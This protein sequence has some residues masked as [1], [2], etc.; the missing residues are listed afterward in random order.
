MTDEDIIDQVLAMMG[1]APRRLA[2]IRKNQRLLLALPRRGA[3][4][5]RALQLYQ[6][7]RLKARATITLVRGTALAGLHY[8][9]LPKIKSR[10]V[11]I[12]LEPAF[13]KVEPDSVGIMVGSP[14]HRV[15]RAIVS[16]QTAEGW[17]VAKVA[18]GPEA[19]GVIAGETAALRSLPRGTPGSPAVLGI[20]HGADIAIMRMPYFQGR[21]IQQGDAAD[22][23]TLLKS[24]VSTEPPRAMACFPEWTSIESALSGHPIRSKVLEKLSRLQIKPVIRHG[25]FARWNLLRMK[26][27]KLMVLDWEWGVGT[28][29]AGIDLVHFFAQ[30]ARL[31]RGLAPEEVIRS[32]ARSLE[33]PECREYLEQTGWGGE[34]ML[35]ILTSIAFTVG[36]RQ[37]ANE[38]VMEAALEAI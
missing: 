4:A 29:M 32:V 9:L 22:A 38:E 18:L 12:L 1:Q 3:A 15:R 23:I 5:R 11:K 33:Q 8:F 27:G 13:P 37:Q 6:P 20:H 28:G 14:E 24:W 16:Y 35:A 17:E 36:A 21:V 10:C 30:D 31:V 19:A 26:D 34:A 7:Q 25:D 2:S